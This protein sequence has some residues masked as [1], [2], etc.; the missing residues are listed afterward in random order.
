MSHV[1]L[2]PLY[3][4]NLPLVLAILV[5]TAV[6]LAQ[7]KPYTEGSSHASDQ[8]WEYKEVRLPVILIAR[9]IWVKGLDPIEDRGETIPG[10]PDTVLRTSA[11]TQRAEA[12][13]EAQMVSVL[14]ATGDE[15]W[16][17]VSVQDKY[18]ESPALSGTG[19]NFIKI[20][21]SKLEHHFYFKRPK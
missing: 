5:L 8:K 7:S 13:L 21:D 18:I 11:A 9:T 16:E 10:Q 19:L 4:K 14:Q 3:M 17:L 2:N 20:S 6:V 1:M 15:G 12:V